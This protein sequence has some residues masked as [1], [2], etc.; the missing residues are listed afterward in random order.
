M[1][2][3]D[4]AGLGRVLS[5]WVWPALPAGFGET[6]LGL[7]ASEPS[8]LGILFLPSH[9]ALDSG[10]HVRLWLLYKPV[11]YLDKVGRRSRQT[12]RWDSQ[13][14]MP[15]TFACPSCVILRNHLSA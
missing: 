3:S 4:Q 9:L 14:G 6:L 12:R 8:S 2:E 15:P 1:G 7:T 13:T 10:E 11:S 5:T